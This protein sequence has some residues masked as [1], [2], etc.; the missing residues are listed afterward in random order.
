MGKVSRT[1]MGGIEDVY[2]LKR[3]LWG[4]SRTF[5]GSFNFHKLDQIYHFVI[6]DLD[7]TYQF[8]RI[9][10]EDVYGLKEDVYGEVS[11]L[12][13]TVQCSINV[14]ISYLSLLNK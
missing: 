8:F 1:F 5:M 14:S 7:L 3:H 2:G 4:V 12:S 11:R 9:T 10:K 13:T 6:I